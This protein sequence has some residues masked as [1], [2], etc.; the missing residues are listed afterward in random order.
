MAKPFYKS[1][2]WNLAAGESVTVVRTADFLA[3]LD[4]DA[5]FDIQIDNSPE[6]EFAKGLTY[7]APQN[8]SEVRIVNN[9]DSSNRIK[10]GFGRGG[11]RDGRTVFAG[12]GL[13]TKPSRGT[14]QLVY[15]PGG[16]MASTT[17]K[18]VPLPGG[19]AKVLIHSQG[20]SNPDLRI[21]LDGSVLPAYRLKADQTLELECSGEIGIATV[22]GFGQSVVQ[23]YVYD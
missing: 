2:Q 13:V 15:Q 22:S 18:V 7:T 1:D 23:A 8:F 5:A 16:G 14:W 4:A 12:G 6:T 9:S 17:K 20:G 10:M 3:C 19:T 21:Y 11:V